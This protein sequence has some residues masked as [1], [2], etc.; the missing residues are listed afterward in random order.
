MTFMSLNNSAL[1]WGKWYDYP[2]KDAE[3][4]GPDG[5]TITYGQIAIAAACGRE[6]SP[7]GTEGNFDLYA[8]G[9][10]RIAD[11]YF[12]C[13]WVGSNVLRVTSYSTLFLVNVP[14]ISSSGAIGDVPV[15]VIYLG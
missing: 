14:S 15:R 5:T 1:P 8:D 9:T 3:I 6:N 7:S 11:I 4:S 13:P 12:D 10:T 2:N